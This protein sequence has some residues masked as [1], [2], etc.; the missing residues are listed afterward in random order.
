MERLLLALALLGAL[1]CLPVRA[2]DPYSVAPVVDG[3]SVR[4]YGGMKELM[5][6]SA[7]ESSEGPSEGAAETV[8][9]EHG[10]DHKHDRTEHDDNLH[11]KRV[12]VDDLLTPAKFSMK[13]ARTAQLSPKK[14]P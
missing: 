12:S 9:D 2:Q 8:D 3:Y 10:G 5:G 1:A 4:Y 14:Q 11:E 13:L 7:A 6:R